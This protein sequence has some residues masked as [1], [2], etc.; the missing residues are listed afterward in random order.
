MGYEI[1][2]ADSHNGAGDGW[3]CA[4]APFLKQNVSS[5]VDFVLLGETDPGNE[6]TYQ[7]VFLVPVL[8]LLDISFLGDRSGSALVL[9]PGQIDAETR[10]VKCLGIRPGPNE[11]WRHL[12]E[13]PREGK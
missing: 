12:R 5:E 1:S 6:L 11:D 13:R 3:G 2:Q 9:R 10:T 4:P 7:L 8:L